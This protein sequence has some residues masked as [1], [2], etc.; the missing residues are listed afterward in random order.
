VRKKSSIVPGG[1][2]DGQRHLA[3]YSV[4]GLAKSH[5]ARRSAARLFP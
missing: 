5:L 1:D 3:L 2:D 4:S